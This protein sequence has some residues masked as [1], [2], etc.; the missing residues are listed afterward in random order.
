MLMCPGFSADGT[1]FP[2]EVIREAVLRAQARV[3]DGQMHGVFAT[4]EYRARMRARNPTSPSIGEI[5]HQVSKLEVGGEGAAY[6]TIQPCDTPQ[7]RAL[8]VAIVK[9]NPGELALFP[10]GKIVERHGDGSIKRL[11]LTSV[12]VGWG[13]E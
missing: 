13:D 7:G 1:F 5:S 8:A 3:Q 10:E 6:A 12:S 11:E 2:A 4:P 9:S